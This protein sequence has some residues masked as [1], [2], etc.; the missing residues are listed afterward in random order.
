[1]YNFSYDGELIPSQLHFIWHGNDDLLQKYK[2]ESILAW[3]DSAAP[4]GYVINVWYDSSLLNRQQ[5]DNLTNWGSQNG[6]NLINRNEK[7]DLTK[8]KFLHERFRYDV[9]G[10]YPN[11]GSA[12]DIDRW[13]ISQIGGIYL[14]ATDVWPGSTPLPDFLIAERGILF[15]HFSQSSPEQIQYYVRNGLKGDLGN[16]AIASCADNSIGNNVILELEESFRE[17][18]LENSLEEQ[19]ARAKDK[20]I[21]R[22]GPEFLSRALFKLHLKPDPN[23]KSV[24]GLHGS[25]CLKPENFN[26]PLGK[27]DNTWLDRSTKKPLLPLKK[28][29]NNKEYLASIAIRIAYEYENF[30]QNR[31][32]VLEYLKLA[33]ET[34]DQQFIIELEKAVLSHLSNDNYK[35]EI[36]KTFASL[37][38]EYNSDVNLSNPSTPTIWN[39]LNRNNSVPPEC[40]N[41]NEEQNKNGLSV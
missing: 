1:M 21:F 20:T 26:A 9:S 12:T 4:L 11:Y 19:R 24:Y 17:D 36:E 32:F 8:N 31:S 15:N 23:P 13:L 3:R 14:D 41:N 34:V 29:A 16:D 18:S 2:A 28:F 30:Q 38:R 10:P 6:I 39:S 27:Q 5:I 37:K 25:L 33:P 22:S 40:N 7:L 35:P